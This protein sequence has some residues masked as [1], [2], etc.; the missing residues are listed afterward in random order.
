MKNRIKILIGKILSFAIL[1]SFSGLFSCEDYLDK[2]PQSDIDDNIPYQ[3]FRNFQGF[4]EELYFLIPLHSISNMSHCSW[5]LGEDEIWAI[6]EM[7]ALASHIDNGNYWH[8]FAGGENYCPFVPTSNF[9]DVSK[10]KSHYS[11]AWYGIRK[12]NL[13]LA[14]L[15]KLVD[16][17]KEERNL[18]EGQLYFFR[19]WYHFILMEYWGGIPYIDTALDPAMVFNLPR[20]SYHAC[21]DKVAADLQKAADLLP[22]N[23]DDTAPGR[24]TLGNNNIRINKVMALAYLGKN[25]L[26]AGS[27]LMNKVSTGNNTYNAEYCKQAAEK[28]GQALKICEDTKRY[29]LYEYDINN[30]NSYHYLYYTRGQGA[31][32]PGLKEAIFFENIANPE[33]RWRWNQVNDYRHHLTVNSGVKVWPTAN[34]TFYYGMKNG[35]PIT[36]ITVAD[37]ES[38]YNPKQPFKDRDP[39][40]YFDFIIDGERQLHDESL[41]EARDK[42]ILYASLYGSSAT[43]GGKLRISNGNNR[44]TTGFMLSKFVHKYMSALG[45]S[46]TLNYRG[47]NTLVMQFMRLADVYLLYAEAA[48]N[49][50]GSPQSKASTYNLTALEAVN[51]IRARAGVDPVHSKFSGSLDGFMSELRRERAVELAFEGHRFTDL[52]RWMLITQKPYTLK[53]GIWFDRDEATPEAE[54]YANPREAKVLNLREEILVERKFDDRHYWFPFRREDVNMYKEF[55]QNPGWK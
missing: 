8:W 21:A 7:R 26:W 22:V 9:T 19:G 18:I 45:S 2:A 48:A 35:L 16:A 38:G 31:R 41:T 33:G 23:W 34:Y 49:G 37:S 50:Y 14:N 43:V 53:T 47:G 1:A 3:N 13:G 44:Q 46:E 27:P 5:N 55:Y 15:D 30:Y 32:L 20:E 52:R 6:G 36:D 39:R 24:V 51:R 25:L 11:S 28:L 12:A 54:R 40:F 42:E 4:V 29:E 17:T 10:N